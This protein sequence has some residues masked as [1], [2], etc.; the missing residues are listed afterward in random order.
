MPNLKSSPTNSAPLPYKDPS[1]SIER[2]T[3]DLLSRMTV[4]E[5]VGQMVQYVAPSRLGRKTADDQ[6]FMDVYPGMTKE[7]MLAH[8]RAGLVGS[9]TNLYDD[10]VSEA[11]EMQRAAAKSR[12]KIPLICGAD[13]IHGHAMAPGATVFPVPIGLAATFDQDLVRQVARATAVEMRATGFQISWGPNVEVV[14]DPRWGRVDETFGEDPLLV[15]RMGV[16][17]VRGLQGD[18]CDPAT[19]VLACA[20]HFL[21]GS[22]SIGGLNHAP[23]EISERALREVFLPPFAACVDVGVG[24]VMASH[25]DLNGVPCHAN[26]PLLSGVL[27]GE[28]GFRGFLISDWLDVGLLWHRQHIAHD[29]AEASEIAVR[30]GLDIHMHGLGFYE[31]VL[32]AVKAGQIPENRVEDAA[33][34]IITAKFALGLF[35]N[36]CTDPKLQAEILRTPEH[37]QLALQSARESIVLLR[38]AGGLL[39]LGKNLPRIFVTGPNAA[40]T[41]PLGDWA[42]PKN[43]DALVTM[44]GGLE[45]ILGGSDRI[46]FFDCG[47][48]EDI[49]DETIRLAAIRAREANVAVLFVGGHP[50]RGGGPGEIS[51][52]EETDRFDLG[53]PG[54]QLD[55]VKAVHSTGL[56]TVVVLLNGGAICEPWLAENVPA[57]VEAFYPGQLGGLAVAEVLF[58]D[59]NPSGKLPYTIPRGAGQ[60]PGYYYQ[61]PGYFLGDGRYAGMTKE[62]SATPLFHFGFG[63]SYTTF[64]YSNLR[65]P[66]TVPVGHDIDVAVDVRNTGSRA[67][68]EV[69]LVFVSDLLSSVTVPV[70]LLRDFCRVHLEPCE[71]K[72][73]SFRLSSH[74]LALYDA[75]LRHLV[76]PGDFSL[77]IA[78]Q[79]AVFTVTLA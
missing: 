29:M 28:L 57:V 7:M 76:E 37:M 4:E 6:G 77:T 59:V 68:A 34:R 70:K 40:D 78:G 62:Q 11:N 26:A 2:R 41:S 51:E 58:G 18:L 46:D 65:V 14:R 12:L 44:E 10:P 19:D 38:N 47:H 54:R 60:L 23:A 36:H 31:P 21:G 15:S 33:R 17:C 16:A 74:A 50:R 8:I 67:G 42:S 35:E 71:T 5:K 22:Q 9:V 25:N 49:S 72:T 45:R 63:L 20:K 13:A 75:N 55:L 43:G 69:V 48:F 64:A 53:L 39:P 52:G 30:A 24:A 27:K 1:L 3:D 79:C 73:V 61:R 66:K 32:A 56:P